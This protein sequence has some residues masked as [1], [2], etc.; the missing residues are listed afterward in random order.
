[1]RQLSKLGI[2]LCGFGVGVVAVGLIAMPTPTTFYVDDSNDTAPHTGSFADPYETITQALLEGEPV[3]GDE[4]VVLPGTYNTALGESWPLVIP[5]GVRVRAY[6]D[7]D[8]PRVGGDAHADPPDSGSYG[9]VFID[10]TSASHDGTIIENLRFLAEDEEEFDP[11]AAVLVRVDS[12]NAATDCSIE[13]CDFERSEMNDGESADQPS[14]LLEV[15]DGQLGDSE[16]PFHIS[17]NGIEPTARGGIELRTTDT[18]EGDAS[19]R[20]IISENIIGLEGDDDAE[21]GIRLAGDG[22]I[23]PVDAIFTPFILRNT[24]DSSLSNEGHGIETG[25]EF[26]AAGAEGKQVRFATTPTIEIIGNTVKACLGDGILA[27]VDTDDD[28]SSYAYFSTGHIEQ[29]TLRGNGAAGLHLDYGSWDVGDAGRYISVDTVGNL[30]VQ[31]TVGIHISGVQDVSSEGGQKS[32]GDTI[33]NNSAAGFWIDGDSTTYANMQNL[34]VYG[35]GGTQQVDGTL[36]W[37]PGSADF[38][39]Y[40]VWE[41]LGSATDPP[42]APYFNIDENPDFVN[43]G[44]GDFTIL[45]GSPCIAKGDITPVVALTTYDIEGEGREYGRVDIG[46]DEYWP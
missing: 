38:I 30:I 35:N 34:I 24:I 31:N 39:D 45:Y 21:F 2:S 6:D 13:S 9:L 36:E 29:N 37:D 42:S 18:G 16:G 25:I 23:V 33:A 28:E 17:N 12:G 41:C 44:A 43:A 27:T 46:A 10:A 19:A 11:P 15:G 8:K 22:R 14:V 7:G 3:S 4:I 32:V 1:M 26:V 5:S 40:C 20:I